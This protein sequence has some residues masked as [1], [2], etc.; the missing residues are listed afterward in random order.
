MKCERC[1]R[2]VD[3][4]FPTAVVDEDSNEEKVMQLCWDC[5]WDIINSW[6]PINEEP[7]EIEERREEEDY[8]YDPVYYPPPRW[9]R[10]EMKKKL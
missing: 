10:E 5:N 7:W 6:A 2:N 8:E 1:E 9:M 3:Q 4:L